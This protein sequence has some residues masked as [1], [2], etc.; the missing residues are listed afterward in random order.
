MINAEREASGLPPI[1]EA[2]PSPKHIETAEALGLGVSA[3]GASSI[4]Y[5]DIS[6][7]V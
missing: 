3:P 7:E 2:G 5:A 4:A 6:S 1:G